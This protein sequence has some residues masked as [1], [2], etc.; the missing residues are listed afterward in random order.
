MSKNADY[1]RG[2]FSL[3]EDAAHIRADQCVDN[4]ET[5]FRDAEQSVQ[6]DLERWYARFATNNGVSLYEARKMLTTGQLEE[7]RWNV[8]QYIQA[9]QQANLSPEWV[10]KLENA[11]ARFHISRLESVQLQIQQ[12]IELLYGNQVDD[13]DSMLKD[14]VSNGYTQ[15]AYEIQKG[16]GLG[17]DMT[18]LDQR[19]LE[20]LLTKPWTADKKT[21]RDRCWE[22]KAGLVSGVQTTLTQGLLRGDSVHKLTEGIKNRFGVSRYQAGRLVRTE[23]TYF[24][25]QASREIYKDIGVS[26]V[27]ILET[28]DRHTCDI[29]GGLDGTVIPLSEY[30]PG[31]TVPPFHPN[32][33]GTTCP[34]IEDKDGE[35]IARNA[36]G[37]VYYVPA[38]MNYQAWKATFV[39]GGAKDGLTVAVVGATMKPKAKPKRERVDLSPDMFPPEFRAKGELKNTNAMIEYVNKIEGA[40]P[41]VLALYGKM[42]DLDTVGS[43]GVP[44]KISHASNHAVQTSYYRASGNLA[45]VKLTIPKLSGEDLTGQITTMLHEEMHLMDLYCRPDITKPGMFSST[46]KKLVSVFQTPKTDIPKVFDD[47][48]DAFDKEC[49]RIRSELISARNAT[50]QAYTDQYYARTLSYSDYKKL[51]SAAMK[52]AEAAIDYQCQNAMG[53]GISSLEDIYDALSGGTAREAGLV[54]YGHGVSYYRDVASR[55]EETLANYGALSVV[56]PD[57]VE[58]LRQE[59][60]ELVEALDEL[61]QEMLKKGGA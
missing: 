1:W 12:Q 48:F 4:L 57:L 59:E 43:Q 17:W 26:K 45:E 21:F 33:R 50:I 27:E 35:R 28:L 32:C 8:D 15:T 14:I 31:V 29:C 19:K 54:R 53:G 30:E 20:S 61:I 23:T 37:E 38:S 49:D 5:I 25:A 6:A 3:L 7:F 44:F 36:D 47:L 10:K 40:D 46:N 22:Q 24:N 2:R 9:A 56:R 34:H 13:I 60:P 16:L 51:R 42:G 58:L 41:D 18:A 11:S 52:E 55:C 39:D